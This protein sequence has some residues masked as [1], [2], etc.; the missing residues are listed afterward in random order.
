[1]AN[2]KDWKESTTGKFLKKQG[3]SDEQLKRQYEINKKFWTGPIIPKSLTKKR[4]RRTPTLRRKYR[5]QEEMWFGNDPGELMGMP[6]VT[7]TKRRRS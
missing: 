6:H 2:F 7:R 3:L 1:M 4:K 5:G